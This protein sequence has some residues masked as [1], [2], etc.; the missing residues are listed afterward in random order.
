M[1]FLICVSL[2][3]V[4]DIDEDTETTASTKES[5]DEDSETTTSTEEAVDEAQTAT[6]ETDTEETVI[7]EDDI[8]KAT[9]LGFSDSF[10]VWCFVVK[11][12]NKTDQEITVYPSDSSVDDEMVTFT[13]GVPATMR[14]GKSFT[15]SWILNGE[16]QKNIEFV[17]TAYDE[18]MNELARTD[19]ITVEK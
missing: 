11:L 15:Q 12:E 9:S 6:E 4:S 18:N 2:N 10:G 5:V 13:S 8:F 16:P 1:L 7:Y 17:M 14:A 3:S 19:L